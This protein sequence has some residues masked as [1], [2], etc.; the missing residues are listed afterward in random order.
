MTWTMRN[1]VR[2]YRCFFWD[3]YIKPGTG[4]VV[5][6]PDIE[7]EREFRF[8]EAAH[9][10]DCIDPN[11]YEGKWVLLTDKLEP[12]SIQEAVKKHLLGQRY[13]LGFA[14]KDWLNNDY[15]LAWK[16]IPAELVAKTHFYPSYRGA[17]LGL[18]SG[19]PWPTLEQQ[20]TYHT[21]LEY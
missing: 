18:D 5:W 8:I 14:A 10:W 12:T 21:L 4:I 9:S 7:N 11:N 17:L 1:K 6:I 16:E 13:R 3:L 20:K 15:G 19:K 2:V